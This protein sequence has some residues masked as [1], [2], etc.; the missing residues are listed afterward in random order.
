[1]ILLTST[2]FAAATNRPRVRNL[3]KSQTK[4]EI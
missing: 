3:V 4:P 2:D 1:M